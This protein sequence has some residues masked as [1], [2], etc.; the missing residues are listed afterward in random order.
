MS[1]GRK[2]KG[3]TCIRCLAWFTAGSRGWKYRAITPG[4]TLCPGCNLSTGKCWTCGDARNCPECRV[5][6]EILA[7]TGRA[8]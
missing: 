3:Y 7:Q 4:G 1:N 5:G 6:M 2:I 8:A